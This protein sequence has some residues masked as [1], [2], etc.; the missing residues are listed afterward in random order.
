MQVPRYLV[1]IELTYVGIMEVNDKPRIL[2]T[3]HLVLLCVGRLTLWRISSQPYIII[4]FLGVSDPLCLSSSFALHFSDYSFW[5]HR[6]VDPGWPATPCTCNGLW[7]LRHMA[8]SLKENNW[9]IFLLTFVGPYR[10]PAVKSSDSDRC[11]ILFHAKSGT[12][13]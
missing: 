5:V 4:N 12:P 10:C 6:L 1:V 11:S 9:L 7:L 13:W 8:V 2:T 3:Y